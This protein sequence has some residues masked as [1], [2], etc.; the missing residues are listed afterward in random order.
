MHAEKTTIIYLYI[1]FPSSECRLARTIGCFCWV[2]TFRYGLLALVC[3]GEETF[4]CSY[5]HVSELDKARLPF[6]N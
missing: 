6:N 2:S 5:L 4:L 3:H 1:V